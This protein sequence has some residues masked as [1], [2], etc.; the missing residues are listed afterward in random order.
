MVG[1][2]QDTVDSY[3]QEDMISD[4]R[5]GRVGVGILNTVSRFSIEAA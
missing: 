5:V 2:M 3:L 1:L 4:A